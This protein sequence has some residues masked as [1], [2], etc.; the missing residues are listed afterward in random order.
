[1]EDLPSV[2]DVK[3]RVNKRYDEMFFRDA[4]GKLQLYVCTVCDDVLMAKEDIEYVTMNAIAKAKHLLSWDSLSKPLPCMCATPTTD[5]REA[6]DELFGISCLSSF[7]WSCFRVW[8]LVV[9]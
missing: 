2:E 5:M 8:L 4:N 6:T 3:Q 1:M 7:C 9:Q